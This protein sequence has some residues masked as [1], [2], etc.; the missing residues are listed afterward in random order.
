[1]YLHVST[2]PA[3]FI[4]VLG[5]VYCLCMT[6]CLFWGPGVHQ[7]LANYGLRLNVACHLF[8]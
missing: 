4:Q 5:S 2:Y 1:M 7:A 3:L 6:L 8:M